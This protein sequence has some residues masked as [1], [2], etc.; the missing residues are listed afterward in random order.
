MSNNSGPSF[1][2]AQ[3]PDIFKLNDNPGSGHYTITSQFFNGYQYSSP[4]FTFGSRTINGDFLSQNYQSQR[5]NPGPGA[6][7]SYY[8]RKKHQGGKISSSEQSNYI[9]FN[10]EINTNAFN[11]DEEVFL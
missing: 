8:E 1:P 7:N 10:Q 4:S 11:Q 6:Y 5:N 2:R 9:Q 3:R